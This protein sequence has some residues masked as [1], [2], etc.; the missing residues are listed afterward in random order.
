[1]GNKRPVEPTFGD[2]LGVGLSLRHT[3][4]YSQALEAVPCGLVRCRNLQSSAVGLAGFGNLAE[5]FFCTTRFA[6]A[7]ADWLFSAIAALKSFSADFGSPR[8]R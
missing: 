5:S 3:R 4:C 6:Q 7:D 1:M 8:E 2:W